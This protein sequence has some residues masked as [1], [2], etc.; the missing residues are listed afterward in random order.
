MRPIPGPAPDSDPDSVGSVGSVG[1][2][3]PD[4][5]AAPAPGAPAPDGVGPGPG[6][7]DRFGPRPGRPW[8]R[9]AQDAPPWAAGRRRS[10]R[11]FLRFAAIFGLLTLL[12]LGGLALLIFFVVRLAG[13]DRETAA[14]LWLG[15]C[16][17][18]LTFPILAAAL[19]RRA[20][21][22]IAA[23]LSHLLDAAE[24]VAAGDLTVR[25]PTGG[26]GDFAAL[27]SAFNH[28]VAELALADR[29]RRNLTADV[30]HELRTPLQIIQGNLEGIADGVYPPSPAH[31][32][33]TLAATRTLARLVED[34]RVLSAA[35]AG[36]LPLQWEPIDVHTLLADL[37]TSFSGQAQ[38]AGV[39]L[40]VTP[41]APLPAASSAPFSDQSP[42][43]LSAPPSAP[44]SAPPPAPLVVLGDYGR[45][46]QVLANLLANALRH[47]PPGGAI[48][49]S[50][51]AIATGATAG[52]TVRLAVADTGA[53]IPPA[54]LPFVFDRFYRGQAARTGDATAPTGDAT[55][56]TGDATART[57]DATA[58]M[59]DAGSG[60]GL[61]IAR[62]LV[63]AHG[64]AIAVQS[65]PGRGTTFTIDLPAAT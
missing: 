2:A 17:L 15:A 42:A 27:S 38:A 24:R 65:T 10:G 7:P 19:G 56:P 25:V 45:L 44:L 20:F 36:Q 23:P 50:A 12:V 39:T 13:G 9:R 61:A 18:L 55:A 8:A 30:A 37:A 35:E 28:M 46:E 3:G 41:P 57:G 21:R 22:T 60:L 49:L 5:Q 58:R 54:D 34:L 52:A 53:G 48:T 33:A 31:I 26:R 47:T 51:A 14:L 6:G 32:A 59:R 1:P 43:P 63:A 16:S 64:G 11:L 4:C 62:E 40:S 29:R